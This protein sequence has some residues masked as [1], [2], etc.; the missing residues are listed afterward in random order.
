MYSENFVVAVKVNGRPLREIMNDSSQEREVFLQHGAEYEIYLKN[1]SN[2]K[3]GARIFVDGTDILGGQHII[4]PAKGSSR[5][6]RFLADGN[7]TSGKRLKF[8]AVGSGDP[9]IADPTSADNGLIQVDFYRST[10]PEQHFIPAT[11]GKK[12]KTVTRG[13]PVYG[14]FDLGNVTIGAAANTGD[15]NPDPSISYCHTTMDCCMDEPVANVGATVEGTQS[16]QTFQTIDVPLESFAC[17][18]IKLR[19]RVSATSVHTEAGIKCSK[20]LTVQSPDAIYCKKCGRKLGSVQV[21][22]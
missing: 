18:T 12:C 9:N 7:L 8:V 6:E 4:V 10:E 17:T 1:S 14:G 16:G 22:R 2:K 21:M 3:A 20:C 19:M 13:G 11:F 15:F 5:V